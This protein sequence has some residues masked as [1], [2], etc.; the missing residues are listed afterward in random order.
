MPAPI[1]HQALAVGI[2]RGFLV[3]AGIAVLAL[4]VVLLTIRL[5]REDLAG[6]SPMP[7]VADAGDV[8]DVRDF[9]GALT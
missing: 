3:A 8:D 4:V 6:A 5:R 9:E 1:L 7:G 2:S